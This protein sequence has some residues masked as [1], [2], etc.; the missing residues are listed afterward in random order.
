MKCC[1]ALQS[2]LA[3]WNWFLPLS[4]GSPLHSLGTRQ[5]ANNAMLL[6]TMKQSMVA[7]DHKTAQWTI[8]FSGSIMHVTGGTPCIMLKS[9][10]FLVGTPLLYNGWKNLGFR[11]AFMLLNL[12]ALKISILYKNRIFQHM[13]MIFCAE[14]QRYP[15][16]FH[17]K[18]LTHTLKDVYFIRSWKFKRY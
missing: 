14:F 12:R 16:K 3:N 1:I 13:G 6:E 11:G 10:H 17:T 2:H 15:L 9:Y 8:H 7:N 4:K 18:Y 5:F